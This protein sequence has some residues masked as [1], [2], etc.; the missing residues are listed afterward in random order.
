[1]QDVFDHSAYRVVCKHAWM[2]SSGLTEQDIENVRQ[3]KPS[4]FY[5]FINL[6]EN[7]PRIRSFLETLHANQTAS[8][9]LVHESLREFLIFNLPKD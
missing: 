4:N 2:F 7:A 1:M 9:N 5:G 8:A 3:G 6:E